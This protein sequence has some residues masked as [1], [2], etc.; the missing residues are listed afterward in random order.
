M[1]SI[2]CIRLGKPGLIID[3]YLKRLT[4]EVEREIVLSVWENDSLKETST[5]S[6]LILVVESEQIETLT[7]IIEAR[8]LKLIVA[9]NSRKDFKIV[10]ELKN[11]FDKIFGFIDLSQEIEYNVPILKNYL[12]LHFSKSGVRLEQLSN[13]IN[14]I[15]EFTKSELGRI[16]ELHE[17][18][19]KVRV[20]QLKGVSISSKFMAGE[21]T[22]GEFFEIIHNEQEI[23][24]I[25]AG[26]NS[27]LL[28]S[29][30]LGEIESLKEYSKNPDLKM[31]TE[32]FEKV[33]NH[34]ANENKAELSYC[35]M[36]LN[37]KTLQATFTLRGTSYL[38]YQGEM[39]SLDQPLNLKLKPKDRLSIISEGAIKNWE[40]LS[41]LSNKK[42]FIDNQALETKDLINEFFFEIS[43]NKIGPFLVHDALLAVINIEEAFLYQLS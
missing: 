21:K 26:S 34:F 8:E 1:S 18:L 17:R 29:L 31:L 7:R 25:Q 16:K 20:D 12:N 37:L 10:G 24:F 36:N 39:L 30:I 3:E 23:L 33:I 28:S 41:K 27:Y 19:V 38:F 42:F 6:A 2:E 4:K 13:D 22:G 11:N 9:L 32:K 40:L 15:Y 14:K 43:R 5:K 35:L